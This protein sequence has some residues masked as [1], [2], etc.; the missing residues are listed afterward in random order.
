MADYIGFRRRI[1]L[2]IHSPYVARELYGNAIRR[3]SR[4]DLFG[5]FHLLVGLRRHLGAPLRRGTRRVPSHLDARARN[6]V[7]GRR[8]N[9]RADLHR[10]IRRP[11]PR[12]SRAV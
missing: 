8:R 5:R 11:R 3:D 1:A 10:N 9:D 2:I 7:H 4:V 6:R 12:K